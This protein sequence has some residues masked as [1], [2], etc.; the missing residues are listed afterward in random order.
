MPGAC[1]KLLTGMLVLVTLP[2]LAQSI[3]NTQALVLPL[4][5][6][7]GADGMARVVT[8]KSRPADCLGLVAINKIDGEKRTVSAQG[9]LIEPGVHRINGMAT[10]DLTHCPLSDN[11]LVLSSAADLEVDFEPGDTYYI[12]YYFEP[13]KTDEWKLVVWHV[14]KSE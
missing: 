10:L 13:G 14:E 6:E 2:V 12:G 11:N 9:F 1:K 3:S 5:T 7:E 4:S 8:S